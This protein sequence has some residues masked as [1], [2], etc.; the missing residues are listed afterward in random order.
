MEPADIATI[1][2]IIIIICVG[3]GIPS[4]LYFLVR[5]GFS[6]GKRR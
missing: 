1:W 2:G 6:R 4:I 3:I 5:H